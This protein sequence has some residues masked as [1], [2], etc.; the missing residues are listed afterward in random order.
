MAYREQA[1]QEVRRTLRRSITESYTSQQY[2]DPV[3][4][5][6]D[7]VMA[8]MKCCGVNNYTDFHSAAKFQAGVLEEGLSRKI[9]D[10]CC[11]L[12][13]E[14]ALMKPEDDNCV[15][16]PTTSNSYL[17]QVTVS[18]RG[19]LIKLYAIYNYCRV[20]TTSLF[21]WPRKI[22]M[23]YSEVWLD[24]VQSSS[25]PLSSL[26]VSA[27]WEHVQC[28]SSVSHDPVR[29]ECLPPSLISILCELLSC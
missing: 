4:L 22:L 21:S 26:S 8:S 5:S 19:S 9:P 24:S 11:I 25:W 18:F 16:L 17:Y 6:W 3:T 27:R 1:D 28:L 2:R 20:A 29:C 15:T 13:G 12:Q 14:M 10:S 7:L 23:S